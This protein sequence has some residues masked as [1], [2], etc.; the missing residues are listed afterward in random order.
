[1]ATFLL[2]DDDA[3]L[4]PPLA[5]YFQRFDLT[6]VCALRP[7]V[8]LARLRVGGIDAAILDVMLPEMDGFELCRII[9]RDS[10]LPVIMLTARGDVMER[11]VGLELGADDYLPKPFE[12]RQLVARLQTVLRWREVSPAPLAR[13]LFDGLGI[14]PDTRSVLRNG[15]IIDLTST[16]F[17][18]LFLLA[19]DAGKVF[20]RD[21]NLNSLRD[22]DVDLFYA[23]RGHCGQS[24][25]KKTRAFGRHQNDAQCGLCVGAGEGGPM[26]ASTPKGG[27]FR[28]AR[29]SLALRCTP[30]VGGLCG[31]T[32]RRNR[33]AAEH[34]SA[35][36]MVQR[37]PVTLR[38]SGP[39]VN[40]RSH[41]D[42]EERDARWRNTGTGDDWH[43]N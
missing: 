1:M 4:G 20:S 21:D 7:S 2:I 33:H 11:V 13:L 15:S 17:D 29:H 3:Q 14:D 28:R 6:L 5:T 34:R 41:P 16:E 42:T 27:W 9:L 23:C 39:S 40:W 22:H 8:G 37:L 35:Q 43:N 38:I 36:L 26:S 30:A 18:L 32:G 25:A 10:N 12:P 31:S 24:L 19:K